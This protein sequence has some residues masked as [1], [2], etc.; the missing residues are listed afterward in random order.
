M[1]V[2][3][4][5]HSGSLGHLTYVFIPVQGDTHSFTLEP[6]MTSDCRVPSSHFLLFSQDGIEQPPP[7]HLP[8]DMLV[9]CEHP[10]LYK[11]Y[12]VCLC[13]ITDQQTLGEMGGVCH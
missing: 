12:A 4:E 7:P 9:C 1:G 8:K 5:G 2:G 11:V 3:W 13:L 6:K 10:D